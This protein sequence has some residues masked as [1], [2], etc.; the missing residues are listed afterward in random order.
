[1][2]THIKGPDSLYGN[3]YIYEVKITI[4]ENRKIEVFRIFIQILG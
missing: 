3:I 4:I 2:A 1:M